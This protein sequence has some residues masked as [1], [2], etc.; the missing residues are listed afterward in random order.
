MRTL[1]K[2]LAT[3]IA[4]KRSDQYHEVSK[5]LRKKY[6]FY[7]LKIALICLRGYRGKINESDKFCDEDTRITNRDA[8]IQVGKFYG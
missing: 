8:K 6:P 2:H 1:F 5:L 7:L 4:D 3:L